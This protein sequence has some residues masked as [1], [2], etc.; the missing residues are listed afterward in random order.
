M[1]DELIGV[2]DFET[3]LKSKYDY[4]S[5]GILGAF[6]RTFSKS[7]LT[8]EEWNSLWDECA[9]LI[10]FDKISEAPSHWWDDINTRVVY[11]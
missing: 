2:E 4:V 7:K 8:L 11:T 5:S 9:G 3:I 1:N 10:Y 6:E